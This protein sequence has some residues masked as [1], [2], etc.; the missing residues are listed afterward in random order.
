MTE[1]WIIIIPNLF[2]GWTA[3][4]SHINSVQNLIGVKPFYDHPFCIFCSFVLMI[5]LMIQSEGVSSSRG[6]TSCGFPGSTVNFNS[7]G[8]D[9]EYCCGCE[10]KPTNIVQKSIMKHQNHPYQFLVLFIG[11]S[12][13]IWYYFTHALCLCSS[14]KAWITNLCFV[15]F[16]FSRGSHGHFGDEI[17]SFLLHQVFTCISS[18]AVPSVITNQNHLY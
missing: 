6:K 4:T 15:A 5:F 2:R 8:N 18:H 11:L 13:Q 7:Q 12:G 10:T 14:K 9:C 3:G 1:L 16:V 17:H